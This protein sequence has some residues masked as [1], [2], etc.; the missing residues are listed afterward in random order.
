M[1]ESARPPFYPR[2]E[3]PPNKTITSSK[4]SH[5]P[6]VQRA[7]SGR[8]IY[9]PRRCRGSLLAEISPARRH[10][11]STCICSMS[12]VLAAPNRFGNSSPNWIPATESFSAG[13][14]ASIKVSKQESHSS[15]WSKLAIASAVTAGDNL[16]AAPVLLAHAA[17]PGIALEYGVK[18]LAEVFLAL[19]ADAWLHAYGDPASPAAAP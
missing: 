11:H 15:N 12:R 2:F 14:L 17:V 8:R 4:G 6:P 10:E 9:L 1:P 18:A 19:R 3:K 13:I 5:R 16:T 7:N